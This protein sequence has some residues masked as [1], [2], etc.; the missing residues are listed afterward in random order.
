M[1]LKREE[2]KIIV[3]DT[4]HDIV[5]VLFM[6]RKTARMSA[7]LLKLL[8]PILKELGIDVSDSKQINELKSKVSK[9]EL[10]KDFISN[11]VDYI[12]SKLDE[13]F[14]ESLILDLCHQT[15]VD[16]NSLSKPEVFDIVFQGNLK[17]MGLVLVH[18]I[19]A[20]YSGFLE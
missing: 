17:L 5:T 18:V 3:N 12:C 11:A 9:M 20:N 15:T 2:T 4:E 19:K 8:L 10:P 7:R 6:G 14:V 1:E 13:A 16:G